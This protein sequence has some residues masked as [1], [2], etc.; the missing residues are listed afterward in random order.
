M[1]TEVHSLLFACPTFGPHLEGGVGLLVLSDSGGKTILLL[2]SFLACSINGGGTN[3]AQECEHI[4][5]RLRWMSRVDITTI[6]PSI[7]VRM[8]SKLCK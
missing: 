8:C 5:N 7:F 4:V 2:F 3:P 1:S 6:L